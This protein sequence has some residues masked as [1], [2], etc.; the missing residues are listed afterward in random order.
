MFLKTRILNSYV[1][2]VLHI[3]N[4]YPCFAIVSLWKLLTIE[5]Y[6]FVIEH[7]ALLDKI[8]VYIMYLVGLCNVSYNLENVVKHV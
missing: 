1:T 2:L 3:L 6:W 8:I 4:A 5:R 7:F